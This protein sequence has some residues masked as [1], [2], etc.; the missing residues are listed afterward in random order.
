MQGLN[1]RDFAAAALGLATSGAWP[2]RALAQADTAHPQP[3]VQSALRAIDNYA[4]LHRSTFNLPALTLGLTTGS[5]IDLARYYGFADT[6]TRSPVTSETLFQI[7]SISKLVTAAVLFQFVAEGRLGLDDRISTHLPTVPLPVQSAIT[8]QHLLDHVSGLPADAPI[9]P[10]NGLWTGFAPGA[11]W[12]YSNTGFAILGK[13]A[14]HLGGKPLGRLIEER[15]LMPLGMLR[16]KG[17]ITAYD[18]LL[19]ARGYDAANTTIPYVRG[20]ALEPAGWVEMTEGGGSVASTALDMN[21]LIRAIAD[22]AAGR[23]AF[24]LSP[25]LARRFVTHKVPSGT[26]EM[27]YGN[28]F[29]HVS[30]GKRPYLHHTGGMV[31][32]SSSFH[33]D[34]LS[35]IGAFAS[36][37]IGYPAAY[38]PKALTAFAVDVLG[39]ALSGRPLPR[40]PAL[41]YSTANTAEL[42]GSYAGPGGPVTITAGRDLVVTAGG[43]SA[44]LQPWGGDLYRTAHPLLRDFEIMI[45]RDSAQKVVGFAWGERS[46]VR[47]G[48]QWSP[49]ASDSALARLAGRYANDSPWLGVARIVERGGT[50]YLGTAYPLARLGDDLWRVGEESWSPERARFEDPIDGRPQTLLLS[51]QEFTR[52][53][54]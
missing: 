27:S 50:L 7:G 39:A 2:L 11:H 21:R 17:A 3:A 42:A 53:D 30:G 34:T 49:P 37:S 12:S 28:G 14:E 23:G 4:E 20:T 38:R 47:S 9:F 29:M 10:E 51:G 41:V 18:R 5:G 31:G 43:Q 46:Y 36:A 15:V 44:V 48:S 16:S 13:L 54:L 32:F 24:G 8:V 35:G 26:P 19:Y 52:R 45:E 25:E 1:R 22:A 33:L 40:A 6:D